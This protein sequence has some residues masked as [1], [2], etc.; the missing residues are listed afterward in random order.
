MQ[1]PS[2]SRS[3]SSANSSRRGSANGQKENAGKHSPLLTENLVKAVAQVFDPAL[4]FKLSLRERGI[5]TIKPYSLYGC[6]NL[7]EIDLSFNQ[8]DRIQGLEQCTLLRKLSLI[9][10]RIE[11]VE[12]LEQLENLKVLQLQ[13][14]FIARIEDLNLRMLGT[15]P[16]LAALYLQNIDGLLANPVTSEPSYRHVVLS[17]L[18]NLST[19]DGERKP[20]LTGYSKAAMLATQAAACSDSYASIDDLDL[21]KPT[22]WLVDWTWDEDM[23]EVGAKA[24]HITADLKST[25]SKVNQCK[26]LLDAV[27]KELGNN[28]KWSARK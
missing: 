23:R 15:L 20:H 14:N 13:Q 5:N 6:I 11:R 9:G 21:P 27:N 26:M 19:F 28:R 22:P 25:R 24:R 3:S 8:L 1:M 2:T 10:N 12:G 18:P 7:T 16:N 17:S 4:V